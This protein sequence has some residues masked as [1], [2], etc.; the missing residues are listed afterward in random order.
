MRK[1]LAMVLVL[2]SVA[3]MAAAEEEE[4]A[5]STRILGVGNSFTVDAFALLEEMGDKSAAHRLIL[6]RAIIG[7]SSLEKHVQLARLHEADPTDPAGKP[8]TAWITDGAGKKVREQV[9]LKYL[10]ETGDWDVVTIQQVSRLS[11]NVE[12]YRPH[13]QELMA[14]ILDYA[15]KAEVVLHQTWAYRADGDFDRVFAAIPGYDQEAMYRDLTSA[16]MTIAEELGVRLI[17]VGWA[18]QV[19]REDRPFVPD[20]TTDRTKLEPPALPD[21]RNSLNRGWSWRRPAEGPPVL[22]CDSH[23]AST[24]GKYLAAAVWYEFFTGLRVD[25]LPMQPGGITEEDRVFLARIAHEVVSEGRK[26]TI[27]LMR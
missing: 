2:V 22:Q 12:N 13:A 24:Q 26:P 27:E 4:G 9:S 1:L 15:P 23:H 19:A 16:Y 17:P 21:D 10:L 5:K 8:Y 20:T 11:H 3:W 18:F 7:G 14:Y 25:S 6:G